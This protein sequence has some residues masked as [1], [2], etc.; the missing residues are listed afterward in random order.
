MGTRGA[1]NCA[2]DLVEE[3]SQRVATRKRSRFISATLKAQ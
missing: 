3:L 2:E 1:V